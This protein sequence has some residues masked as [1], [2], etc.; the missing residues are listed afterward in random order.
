MSDAEAATA[1]AEAAADGLR[2]DLAEVKTRLS[3]ANLAIESNTTSH[4]AVG[5]PPCQKLLKASFN[6]CQPS[7]AES[8]ATRLMF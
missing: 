5:T 2:S 8:T 4:A 6:T 7:Y 3:S 1:A